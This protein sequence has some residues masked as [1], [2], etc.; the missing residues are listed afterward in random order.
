MPAAAT[1]PGC[2]CGNANC[3][4]S[5]TRPGW[6]SRSPTSRP[7]RA[8]WNK[9]EHR[10]FAFIG[11]NWRAR[12]LVSYR[13]IVQLIA[14]TTTKTGLKVHCELDPNT[15]PKGIKVSD[16]EMAEI[17]LTR[18]DFHGDWNYTIS[19]QQPRNSAIIV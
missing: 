1:A 8:K 6:R 7:A 5:P 14:A 3:N 15:Y 18:A 4:A 16:K 10:R 2:G 11:Q 19:P 17:N 12:P 13:V 9:I